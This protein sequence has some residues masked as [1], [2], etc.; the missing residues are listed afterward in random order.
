ME[1]YLFLLSRSCVRNAR[2]RMQSNRRRKQILA[3]FLHLK[4]IQGQAFKVIGKPLNYIGL[5][6]VSQYVLVL[7]N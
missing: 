7:A 5:Y 4:V 2:E 6:F 1:V 3:L